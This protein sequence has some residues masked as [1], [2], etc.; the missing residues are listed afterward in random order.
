MTFAEDSILVLLEVDTTGELAGSAAGL[1]AA[2]AS[3]GSPV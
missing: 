1:L 2:A 3:V